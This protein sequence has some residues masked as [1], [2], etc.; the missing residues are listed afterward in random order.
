M[1]QRD[2]QAVSSDRL[3]AMAADVVSAYVGNHHCTADELPD[4]IQAGTRFRVSGG[5]GP[6]E[7]RPRP[8]GRAGGNR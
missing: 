3:L 6:P 1:R 7:G 5:P 8:V 2:A 4:I